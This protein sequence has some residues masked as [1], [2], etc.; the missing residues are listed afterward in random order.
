VQRLLFFMLVGLAACGGDEDPT[1]PQ[2]FDHPSTNPLTACADAS[3]EDAFVL[4]LRYQSAIPFNQHLASD[5]SWALNSARATYPELCEP[6]AFADMVPDVLIVRPRDTKVAAAFRNG[7]S[8]T[9]IADVDSLLQPVGVTEVAAVPHSEFFTLTLAQPVNA[10]A[11]ARA[12]NKT[13]L[14]DA[15]AKDI[16]AAHD[17]YFDGSAYASRTP[18]DIVIRT[19]QKS[20]RI[21][22]QLQDGR[23]TASVMVNHN[24]TVGP[25]E[26]R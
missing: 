26:Q 3:S 23:G 20:S 19:G 16:H 25:L 13:H 21:I 4:A 9:G 14:L 11:L 17:F 8:Q 10:R 24:G 22:F 15:N 7:G 12:L 5:Y 6:R 1:D 18:S 2:E